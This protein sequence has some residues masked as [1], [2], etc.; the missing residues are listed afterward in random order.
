MAAEQLLSQL[1]DIA[2]P[3]YLLPWQMPI[4]VYI[5]LA[6]SLLLLAGAGWWLYQR[7]RYFA[8][9]RHAISLLAQLKPQHSSNINQ[10]LKRVVLHYA[11]AHPVLSAPTEQWQAFLQQQLPVLAL[12]SLAELLYQ[13]EPDEQ[14]QHAFYQFAHSW[15]RHCQP[16]KFAEVVPAAKQTEAT[17]A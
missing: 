15:L 4:G 12:P 13:P 6:I 1:V 2:E 5:L 11:P 8:A 16:E 14:Q 7:H 3:A 17:N 9:R 10:L